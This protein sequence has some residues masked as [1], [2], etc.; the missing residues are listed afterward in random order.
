VANPTSKRLGTK[1]VQQDDV[2]I[3]P[4]TPIGMT[5][6]TADT[7]AY[8]PYAQSTDSFN[9]SSEPYDTSQNYRG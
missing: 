9:Q 5:Y 2:F 4:V 7:Q 8:D 1:S 3:T 6:G